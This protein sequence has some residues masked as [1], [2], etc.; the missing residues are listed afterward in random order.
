M[1]MESL[2]ETLNEE[3]NVSVTENGAIG[4]KTTGKEL[5]DINFQISSMRDMFEKQIV[6]KFV[7][8]FYENKLL[9]IKWLFFVRD[10]REGIGERRL[11][12]ICIKYLAIHHID[13]A[14]A[15]LPLI[16]EYGRYDGILCLIDTDLVEYIENKINQRKEAKQ[17]KDFALADAI[18]NEL[19]EK[20]IE[21]KDTREGTIWNKL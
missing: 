21:L 6:D 11:F 12:R 8:A 13:I 7:K 20:G 3:F 9:A 4:Y 2:K 18:R 1:F 15:I 10:I 19:L 5:L 17:N 14:K 16:S